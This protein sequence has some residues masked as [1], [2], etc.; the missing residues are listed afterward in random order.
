MLIPQ[1]QELRVVRT[2]GR[3]SRTG[4]VYHTE[5]TESSSVPHQQPGKQSPMQMNDNIHAK[6][7][8]DRSRALD[9]AVGSSGLLQPLVMQFLINLEVWFVYYSLPML[10]L[11]SR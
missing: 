11:K 3:I 6:K 4:G 2:S 8:R 7:M 10:H 9:S 5:D 1:F